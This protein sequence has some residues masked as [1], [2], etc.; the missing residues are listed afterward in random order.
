MSNG[1]DQRMTQFAEEHA[2]GGGELTEEC[3]VAGEV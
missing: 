3:L 1:P 2:D